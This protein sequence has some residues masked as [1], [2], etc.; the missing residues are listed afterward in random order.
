[1]WEYF[2]APPGGDIHP[3]NWAISMHNILFDKQKTY[4]S[5][6]TKIYHYLFG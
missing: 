1:V 5:I 3:E 4:K 6:F 2:N